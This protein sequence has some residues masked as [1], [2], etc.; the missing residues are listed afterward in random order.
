MLVYKIFLF[1][2]LL[3][4]IT[5]FIRYFFLRKENVSV[6][7]FINGLKEENNGQYEEA[8]IN[9]ES[10]LYEIKKIKRH[11]QLKEKLIEKLSTLRTVIAYKNDFQY[12]REFDQVV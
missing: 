9:Y 5:F 2:V 4:I 3:M 1:F 12:R 6:Q 8:V 10:A 11:N 7:L